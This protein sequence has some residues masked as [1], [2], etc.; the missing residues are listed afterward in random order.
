MIWYDMIWCDVIYDIWYDMIWCDV[1]I[2]YN[3]TLYI[4]I[5]MNIRTERRLGPPS[6]LIVYVALTVDEMLQLHHPHTALCCGQPVFRRERI[7]F[8]LTADF[9]VSA[10][11]GNCAVYGTEPRAVWHR[12]T[13]FVGHLRNCWTG[14]TQCYLLFSLEPK[15]FILHLLLILM[16]NVYVCRVVIRREGESHYMHYRTFWLN[17]FYMQKNSIK[18]LYFGAT[19]T[20]LSHI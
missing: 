19:S 16:S 8:L 14:V 13:R 5:C 7:P 15:L 11:K 18:Y 2:W 17:L 3:I 9:T 10:L 1:M 20:F 6:W 12:A 4:Y